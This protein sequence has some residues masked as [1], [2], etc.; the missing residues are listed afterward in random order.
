[1]CFSHLVLMSSKKSGW[2][3]YRFSRPIL[4]L[5]CEFV[6]WRCSIHVSLSLTV[7]PPGP[8][9]NT[10]LVTLTKPALR[11][12]QLLNWIIHNALENLLCEI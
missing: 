1:M 4:Y 2:N 7:P 3:V 5:E 12:P 8:I 6:Q 10:L 9:L 11:G